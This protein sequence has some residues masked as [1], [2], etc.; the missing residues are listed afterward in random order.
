MNNRT[1]LISLRLTACALA[2]SV[3]FGC[4]GSDTADTTP[5]AVQS[6]S[7][8]MVQTPTAVTVSAPSD[9]SGSPLAA[10]DKWA[11]MQYAFSATT[12]AGQSYTGTLLLRSEAEDGRTEWEG[13][14]T[15]GVPAVP[16]A[17]SP[18]MPAVQ[19]DL[20]SQLAAL[21]SALVSDIDALRQKLK[22]DLRA[23]SDSAQK[24]QARLDFTDAFKA[25]NTQYQDDVAALMASYRDLFAQSGLTTEGADAKQSDRGDEAR[26]GY[27]VEGSIAAD[28]T[29]SLTIELGEDRELKLRGTE[30]NGALSGTF[31]GPGETD[32]GTW[33]A[34]AGSTPAPAPAPAR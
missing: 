23:A 14:L 33:S 31:T 26:R 7:V 27:E 24:T 8:Q 10:P 6:E 12:A 19:T 32:T 11:A 29:I 22:A 3:L 30:S 9:A 34:T 15:L 1:P 17:A 13:R 25:L 2:V 5:T 21:R 28:G 20:T 4:G 16:T 18:Q